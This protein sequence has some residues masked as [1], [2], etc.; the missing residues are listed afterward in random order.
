M[1]LGL[2]HIVIMTAFY[3]WDLVD[4]RRHVVKKLHFCKAV[5]IQ[6]LLHI[7]LIRSLYYSKVYYTVSSQ[8]GV[9][10]KWSDP[11]S[12]DF[13]LTSARVCAVRS[14]VV[15]ITGL[16]LFVFCSFPDQVVTE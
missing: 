15:W 1:P 7:T 14:Q 11:T 12:V 9:R 4:A 8:M 13:Q 16:P 5:H 2:S 3:F 6:S 10:Q